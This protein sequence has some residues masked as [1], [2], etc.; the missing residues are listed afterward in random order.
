ML[1]RREEIRKNVLQRAD[2]RRNYVMKD[3]VPENEEFAIE[4]EHEYD[5]V[6]V[7]RDTIK[8]FG[9]KKKSTQHR[10]SVVLLKESLD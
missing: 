9:A 3:S 4:N 6:F 7:S 2:P 1:L 10:D 8:L 5:S